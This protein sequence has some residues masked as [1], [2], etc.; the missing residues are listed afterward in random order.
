MPLEF[1]CIC[2]MR[3]WFKEQRSLK[4]AIHLKS[5]TVC[6]AS[7]NTSQPH[8]DALVSLRPL[9]GFVLSFSPLSPTH[10]SPVVS[11]LAAGIFSCSPA[12]W[13]TL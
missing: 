12:V 4:K 1:H 11:A 9:Q 8:S 6:L 10:P 2:S 3:N 7:L 13:H 5:C